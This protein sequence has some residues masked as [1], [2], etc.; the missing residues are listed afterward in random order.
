MNELSDREV[1]IRTIYLE[2]R[3][4]PVEGQQWVAW[5]IKNRARLNRGYWGGSTIRGVCLE[6]GQFEC[7]N[8]GQD[9]NIYEQAVYD[10]IHRWG[11]AIFDADGNLDPTG[12]ADHYNNPQKEG[13][14]SWTNNCDFLRKI[15]EHQFYRGRGWCLPPSITTIETLNTNLDSFQ[16][17]AIVFQKCSIALIKTWTLWSVVSNRVAPFEPHSGFVLLPSKKVWNKHWLCTMA[18]L[19]N[20]MKL[21]RS[22]LYRPTDLNQPEA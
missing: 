2:A 12:G 8:P 16:F 20:L 17:T 4:E 18:E 13:H 6:P 21:N 5:V 3:G 9:I 15:G 7:W 19:L 10:N 1:F 22:F 11:V 14:P